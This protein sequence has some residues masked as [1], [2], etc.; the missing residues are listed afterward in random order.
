MHAKKAGTRRGMDA[1]FSGRDMKS[2]VYILE[3][4]PAL[5]VPVTIPKVK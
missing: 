3:V 5:D 2:A 1:W 4:H